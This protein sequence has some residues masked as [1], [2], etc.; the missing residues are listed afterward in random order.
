[1]SP[2][3]GADSPPVENYFSKVTAGLTASNTAF[4]LICLC[5][6]FLS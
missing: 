5:V 3:K 1:M 6:D 2:G 4:V